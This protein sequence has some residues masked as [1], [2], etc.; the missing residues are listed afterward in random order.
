MDRPDSI[1]AV[2]LRGLASFLC[3]SLSLSLFVPAGVGARAASPPSPKKEKSKQP[4]AMDSTEKDTD[5]LKPY[6]SMSLSP[7]PLSP[8][9]FTPDFGV[10]PTLRRYFAE[11]ESKWELKPILGTNAPPQPPPVFNPDPGAYMKTQ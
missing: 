8:A 3:S 10:A 2:W 11:L 6:Q 1:V 9:V 7:P 4:P 5:A